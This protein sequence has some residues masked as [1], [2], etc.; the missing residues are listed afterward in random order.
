MR[1]PVEFSTIAYFAVP[2][3]LLLCRTHLRSWA[4]YSGLMA[5][6]F[7][8]LA[9]ILVGGPLYQASAPLDIYISMLCHGTIYLCGFVCIGTEQHSARQAP[10]LVLGVALVA[11]WAAAFHDLEAGRETFLIY[12]LMDALPVRAVVPQR[13][14]PLALPVYYGLLVSFVL[15]TIRGFFRR[16]RKQYLRF[17]A[18]R[19]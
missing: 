9:M 18:A 4:A 11:L 15:L 19:V 13:F 5:G 1:V 10:V 14:L 16:S 17:S 2:A 12:I 7:Y 8:Y 6:F 3:I